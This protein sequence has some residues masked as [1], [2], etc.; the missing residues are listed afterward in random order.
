MALAALLLAAALVLSGCAGAAQE[1]GSTAA[2]DTTEQQAPAEQQTAEQADAAEPTEENGAVDEDEYQER[3]QSAAQQATPDSENLQ[4]AP[5]MKEWNDPA[6]DDIPNTAQFFNTGSSAGAIPA[7][8]PFNFGRD[9]GG[10]EDKTMYLTVPKIGLEDVE[11]IDSTS[12]EALKESTVHVP[13]TGFPWQEGANTYIA[14][15]RVGYPGTGSYEIFMDLDQLEDGDEIFVED[16]DG[17][18]YTYRVTTY[19]VTDPFDVEVMNPVDDKS[20]ITLQTC[21][22]PDYEDRIVVQG[23]LVEGEFAD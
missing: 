13:A 11:V 10:P 17:N 16:A 3:L 14:G 5:E 1:S 23:E 4:G 21:T 2:P 20:V 19:L 22:L 6:G 9:P 7:V 18:S 8:K 12:D 15:H